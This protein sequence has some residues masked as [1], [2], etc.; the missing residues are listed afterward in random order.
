MMRYYRGDLAG[1]EEHF[2]RGL[3]FFEDASIWPLPLLRLNPLG[4]ASWNVWNLG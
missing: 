2:A 4:I 1:T 3:K